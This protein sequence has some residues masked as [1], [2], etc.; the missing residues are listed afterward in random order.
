MPDMR[1]KMPNSI[2]ALKKLKPGHPPLPGAGRP[3]DTPERI[4][5]KKAIKILVKEYK[6]NLA[7]VLPNLAPVLKKKALTGDIPAIKELHDRVMDKAKQP[8]TGG[9]DDDGRE[10]P[11]FNFV[12]NKIEN[13]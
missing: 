2:A 5:Q 3:K 10:I 11:L 4:I 1:G 6:E 8:L 7:A 9:E 13:K 12:Q